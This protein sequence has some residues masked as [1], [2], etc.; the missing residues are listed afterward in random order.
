MGDRNLTS[1]PASSPKLAFRS[2]SV[3]LARSQNRGTNVERE[4]TSSLAG[5]PSHPHFCSTPGPPLTKRNAANILHNA[6]VVVGFGVRRW[7]S[8]D[9]ASLTFSLQV[10]E[11]WQARNL[12]WEAAWAARDSNG[13]VSRADAVAWLSSN[14]EQILDLPFAHEF[15]EFVAYEVGFFLSFS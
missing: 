4:H 6:G 10:P 1:S 11:E 2:S 14:L 13:E 9:R 3:L 12:L 15:E 7:S 5:A 8:L